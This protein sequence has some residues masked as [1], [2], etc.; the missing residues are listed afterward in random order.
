MLKNSLTSYDVFVI[1]GELDIPDGLSVSRKAGQFNAVFPNPRSSD[2]MSI[3]ASPS[4]GTYV[5]QLPVAIR[6]SEEVSIEQTFPL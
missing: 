1:V 3:I 2:R 4:T 5:S 6:P